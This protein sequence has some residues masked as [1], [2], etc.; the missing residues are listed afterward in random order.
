M[1][2]N[3]IGYSKREASAATSLSVRSIDYLLTKGVLRGVKVGKRIVI[4]ADSL[5]RL[6]EKGVNDSPSR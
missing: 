3:K 5:R 6:V 4:S 2:P 1:Q